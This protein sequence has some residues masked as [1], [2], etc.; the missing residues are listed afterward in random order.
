MK[1]VDIIVPCYNEQEVLSTYFKTTDP[2]VRSIDGYS[3]RY[4]FIDDGS[5][6]DTLLLVKGLAADHDYVSYISFSRNFGKEAGIYAGLS[7]STGDYVIVMDADLQHPPTLIPEFIKSI[8]AG[9]D[10]CAAYRET[11]KGENP[12][13]NALSKAFY[14]LSNRMS[15]TKMPSS[16]VDYRIMSRPM[17]NAILSMP[18]VQRFSKG[19]FIWVGFDVEWIPYENVTRTMGNS[20]YKLS[21]LFRYAMDG[22]LSF[23]VKPLRILSITGFIISAAAIIYALFILIRTLVVGIDSPGYASTVII[24]LF[25]GGIIELSIGIL[26]EYIARIYGEV[27]HRPIYLAKET[28]LASVHAE[29]PNA[30]EKEPL[31]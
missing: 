1:T 2:I 16:A 18:E 24:L 4:L 3:F 31:S 27:K 28:H 9:H 8:E 6:D 11:R 19:M 30:T 22:I 29:H 5:K 21:G 10:C 7:H 14:K 12:F 25:L 20:K 23:S 15:E 13:R 17:V 26:G